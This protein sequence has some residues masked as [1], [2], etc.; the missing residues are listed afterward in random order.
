[1]SSEEIGRAPHPGPASPPRTYP[2]VSHWIG[3]IAF[4]G[5]GMVVLGTFH[6]MLGLVALLGGEQVLTGRP[7]P[8]LDLDL[9]SWGWVHLVTGCLVVFAA[10][11]VF[12]GQRW[13]R[14]VGTVIAL[15]SVVAN[16]GLLS[17]DPIRSLVM[18]AIGI[19]VVLAL[20]VHGSDVKP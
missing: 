16:F 11:C 17:Q 13:A 14:G 4:A 12:A 19:V 7:D 1:M 18:I 3:W 9:T 10:L 15:S 2:T 5:V 8:L 6:V 20:T